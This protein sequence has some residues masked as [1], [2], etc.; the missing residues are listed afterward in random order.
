MVSVSIFVLLSFGAFRYFSNIQNIQDS[1]PHST[2][3]EVAVEIKE[4]T[5][6]EE[7]PIVQVKPMPRLISEPIQEPVQEPLVGQDAKEIVVT[8]KE[9][10]LPEAAIESGEVEEKSVSAIQVEPEPAPVK[11]PPSEPAQKP[12]VIQSTEK[13]RERVA[14]A[15]VIEPVPEATPEISEV[16]EQEVKEHY[17][18]ISRTGER[19]PDNSERWACIEDPATGLMWEVKSIDGGLHDSNNLYSWYNPDVNERVSGSADGGRCEGGTDCDTHAF[20]QAVISENY[21]GYRDWRVPTRD[22][23]LK[24]VVY[25]GDEASGTIDNDYFPRALPSWY[26]TATSNGNHPDYAWY[27]LFRNGVVLS[28]RKAHSKHLRLV[29]GDNP[30]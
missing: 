10:T 20:V 27:V 11:A 3:D 30:A 8:P 17:I 4:T 24:I 29:R 7:Q 5:V 16:E 13:H 23:L 14:L 1:T 25:S 12:M 21:C 6:I 15:P 28:D 19:L 22:E 2:H 26:W 18:K 9:K